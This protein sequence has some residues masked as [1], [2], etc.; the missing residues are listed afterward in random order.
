ML[1]RLIY[2]KKEISIILNKANNLSNSKKR[3]L[4]IESFNIIEA[5]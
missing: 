1:E 5:D 3:D 4:N 2:F